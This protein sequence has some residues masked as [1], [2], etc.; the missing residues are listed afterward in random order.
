M[1]VFI[2][3]VNVIHIHFVLIQNETK[4]QEKSMLPAHKKAG[5][6]SVPKT[7]QAADF[8]GLRSIEAILLIIV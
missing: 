4:D 5:A 8:L 1:V 7:R 2:L 3:S 6:R